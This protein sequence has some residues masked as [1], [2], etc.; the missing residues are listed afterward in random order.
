VVSG[1]GAAAFGTLLRRAR[2]GA[3]LELSAC[4]GAGGGTGEVADVNSACELAARG[5]GGDATPGHVCS[6][7][8]VAFGRLFLR[9][10]VAV[11]LLRK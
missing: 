9:A 10:P 7:L 8:R 5:A 11:S 3:A 2:A 6:A 1:G 4:G